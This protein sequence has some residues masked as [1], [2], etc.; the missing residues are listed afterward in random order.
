MSRAKEIY[1]LIN[2]C[3][4]LDK[5]ENSKLIL[6]YKPSGKEMEQLKKASKADLLKH[7]NIKL[8]SIADNNELILSS[9]FC[10]DGYGVATHRSIVII[11][12]RRLIKLKNEEL[13]SSDSKRFVISQRADV[14]V[15][16][17]DA[18]CQVF[19][20]DQPSSWS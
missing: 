20:L 1:E 7:K 16:Y 2:K 3:C 19:S 9:D 12:D 15:E 18:I 5:E 10:T 4:G 17:Q 14:A 8:I 11:G 13:I 6:E